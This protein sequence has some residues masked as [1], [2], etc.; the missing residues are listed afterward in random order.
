MATHYSD[1]KI[2]QTEIIGCCKALNDVDEE[3]LK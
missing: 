1:P 3:C 2:E